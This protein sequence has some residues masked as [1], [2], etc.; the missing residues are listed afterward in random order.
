MKTI[1][2]LSLLAPNLLLG[3]GT[4]DTGNSKLWEMRKKMQQR[5]AQRT[6][7]YVEQ[8]N[9][10]L[11]SGDA[12]GAES[13]L[14]AAIAQ[15]TLTQSQI[16]DARGRI[17]SMVSQQRQAMVAEARA[18]QEAEARAAEAERMAVADSA[19][20]RMAVPRESTPSSSRTSVSESRSSS[21]S[22]ASTTE[23]QRFSATFPGGYYNFTC[24][25]DTNAGKSNMSPW[26]TLRASNGKEWAIQYSVPM[27]L[28]SNKG[29]T[30]GLATDDR[31]NLEGV[32]MNVSFNSAGEPVS[33]KNMSNGNHCEVKNW[34]VTGYGW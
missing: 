21:P 33:I 24:T 5:S 2:I 27:F 3:Q 9:Q 28:S 6:G 8:M 18:K 4:P 15:G 17:D 13:A 10:A 12:E 23:S 32:T 31:Q 20:S 30:G 25:R 16:N 19:T 22:K 26:L 34:K 11:Q 7:S 29:K 1:L 14:K